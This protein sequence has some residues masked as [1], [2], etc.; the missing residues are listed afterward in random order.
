MLEPPDQGAK[1]HPRLDEFFVMSRSAFDRIADEAIR[2]WSVFH[3]ALENANAEDA[4]RTALAGLSGVRNRGERSIAELVDL[5]RR[6]EEL[7]AEWRAARRYDEEVLTG[8]LA[9]LTASVAAD[10]ETGAQDWLSEVLDA[11]DAREWDAVELLAGR[12][13]S[14]P[15]A[16]A[17]GAQLIREAI[18]TWG[19]GEDAA[20]L[21]LMLRLGEKRL[22]GW[23]DVLSPELRSRAHRLAAWIALR[24]LKAPD[25]A[26]QHLGR[27]IALWPHAGRMHAERAAYYLS[28]GDLDRAAT[29]AQHSVE[30]AKDD[31]AGYLELGIWA[32]LSGDF[33]DAD[34]FYRKALALLQTF[35]VARLAT[36]ASLIDPSGRLL[37]RAAER[38]LQSRRPDDALMIA[39]AALQADQ[40][41]PELHPQAA[42]HVARSIA[43]EQR[44]DHAAAA[45]AAV[46]AGKLHAWNGDVRLAIEQFERAEDLDDGLQDVGWLLADARLTMS[47]PRG[48][49]LTDQTAVGKALGTWE[50]WAAKVGHP[51]GD[52]SWAYLT[53]AMIADLGT[54]RPGVDRLAGVWEAL[55]YV[56]KALV[57]DEVDAQRW[58][59]A[60]QY[61][62]YVHLDELAFEAADRGYKLGSGDRQVLAE[63]LAQLAYRGRF[64]EADQV[65]DELVTM[66][67]NDPWV[68]AARAWLAI[69]SHRETRYSDGL[70][71]LELPLAGGNDPSW[72]YEMR[73]LC[74]VGL[75]NVDAARQDCRELLAKALPVDGTTKCRLQVAAVAV[76]NAEQAAHWSSEAA[77][78][79]TSRVITC[80]TADAFAAFARDDLD[81]ATDLL[82]RAAQLATSVIELRDIVDLM[83]LRLPLLTDDPDVASAHERTLQAIAT[84]PVRDSERTLSPMGP[85]QELKQACATYGDH[86]TAPPVIHLALLA[87]SARRATQAGRLGDAAASY[88]ELLSSTFEPEA[89]IGL[90]RT[91]RGL[92]KQQAAAGDVEQV[93]QLTE[94]MTALG[95]VSPADVASTVASALERS[96]SRAEAREQLKTAIAMA[97]DDRERAK[98]H[99]RAGGLALADDDLDDASLH[100]QAALETAEKYD[101]HAR[102]GQVQIRMALIAILRQDPAA[103]REHLLAAARAWREGGALDPTAALIGELRGLQRLRDGD[104]E[105]AARDALELV[106]MAVAPKAVGPDLEPLR[107][108]L[109]L[110]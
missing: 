12:E 58:G 42:S 19:G 5:T 89:T 2:G 51:R 90:A 85:D 95:N 84:G 47:L 79:P 81:Q 45:A 105:A 48:A 60:A 76:G 64:D 3:E 21:E 54:Q 98:L 63:R 66:F 13:L 104:W 34:E 6:V 38:L 32:E 4:Y 11:L 7:H 67:G 70:G 27:A 56:E 26:E 25:L 33:D 28:I 69:H 10:P 61:L 55:L 102:K 35:D 72:Y 49:R 29:D 59:Y 97:A 50:R 44:R 100:L 1:P 73:A 41:G 87:V 78:D 96:G 23:E 82:S 37:T 65:A 8:L 16:L 86:P 109:G 103:A 20:G 57:H 93:R 9:E 14:W 22:A 43:L 71:L 101:A 24:R 31:A 62:R 83:R 80:L 99:Q 40:R 88:Q 77:Q 30:L 52:T 106:E 107:R 18:A 108:E 94:R 53:R 110:L 91:L 17:G 92:A 39:D 15:D 75:Q 68:S 46:R 74:H 36:R